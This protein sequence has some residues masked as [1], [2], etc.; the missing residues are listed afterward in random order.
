MAKSTWPFLVRVAVVAL[1]LASCSGQ[2]SATPAS[3]N[4]PSLSGR[5]ATVSEIVNVVE[6]RASAGGTFIPIGNQF[7]LYEGWQIRTGNASGARLDLTGGAII[8]IGPNSSLTIDRITPNQSLLLIG[9]QLEA[10]KI[11]ISVPDGK[12]EVTSPVGTVTMQGAYGV[13][14]YDSAADILTVDCITGACQ[15]ANSTVDEKLGNLEQI[16]LTEG[17]QQFTRGRL[18]FEAVEDFVHNNPEAGQSVVATLMAASTPIVVSETPSLVALSPTTAPADT[19]SPTPSRT[20]TPT[21]TPT[22]T[23]RPSPT[24]TT[25]SCPRGC[26]PPPPP[27]CNIKGNISIETGEKIY[28]VPGGEF[29]EVTNISPEYGELWFCTEGEAIANGWRKSQR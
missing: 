28:H 18:G 13:I 7:I 6:A 1:L 17:G 11:W 9:L 22:A 3:A 24:A 14:E 4:T 25:P 26:T 15:V 20:L 21:K 2:T 8:R 5:T 12:L 27:G 16:V 23:L 29:Y 19:P 10:G